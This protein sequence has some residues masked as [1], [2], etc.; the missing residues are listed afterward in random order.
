MT[1]TLDGTLGVTTPAETI[2]GTLAVTGITTV[3]AGTAAAPSIVSTT[4]TADTGMWF[5]AADTVAWS[6]AG[7]ERV[8]IGS[9]GLVGIGTTTPAQML[10]IKATNQTG[11]VGAA[12][13]NNNGNIGIAGTQF[14]SDATYYKAAIGLLRSHPNGG[15]SIVFYNDSNTDA[16]DWATT[17]E[18]MRIDINGN[19]TLQK[20]ISVGAA[21]PTTSGTGIT[22]PA[23][24]SASTDANTL[25]DYEEGTWTPTI[26]GISGGSV[27]SVS[28][29]S[30]TYTKIGRVVNVNITAIQWTAKTTLV[31]L[32]ALGGLP[33]T[34]GAMRYAGGAGGSGS[35]FSFTGRLGCTADPGQTF[36]YLL[37]VANTDNT[38]A[39]FGDASVLSTGI[40]Y[41]IS[42]TYNI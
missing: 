39:H 1:I 26:I 40:M 2:T 38:Y 11:F 10:E 24:Q 27:T 6:T 30:G 31:S 36:I 4:G 17:D 3:A 34:T 21:A 9:T 29:A 41:G 37:A 13:Q 19:V 7:S 20:N 32:V 28:G 25:D 33:F 42:L 15:G 14:A 12:I 18:K 22:F 8:R 5:P 23:T 16:A 35:G